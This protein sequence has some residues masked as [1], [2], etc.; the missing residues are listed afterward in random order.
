MGSREALAGGCT[1][2]AP[3]AIARARSP[4]GAA[5]MVLALETSAAHSGKMADGPR[6]T[7]EVAKD[8]AR[9]GCYRWNV[10]ENMRLRDKS[11]Y[12]LSGKPNSTRINSCGGSMI[13]GRRINRS[14]LGIVERDAPR[15]DT[16]SP[17]WPAAGFVRRAAA[18]IGSG[19]RL[20]EADQSGLLLN[21]GDRRRRRRIACPITSTK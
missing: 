11:L 19:T 6:F 14:A 7:I 17:R 18:C 15:G 8:A 3:T 21:R 10:S 9:P 13:S 1:C 4:S 12:S 16:R 20:D 2:G 5:E